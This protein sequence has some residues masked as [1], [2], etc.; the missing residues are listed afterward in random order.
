M[1]N[2]LAKRFKFITSKSTKG[3]LIFSFLLTLFS[4]ILIKPIFYP[5]TPL[6]SNPSFY[7]SGFPWAFSI[8]FPYEQF[9]YFSL[10][11]FLLDLVFWFIVVELILT[12][13]NL[14][15]GSQE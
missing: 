6:F 11:Y 3:I 4:Y 12:G 2:K 14:I 1:K 7:N 5:K 15:K 8:G 13:I 10:L 9:K